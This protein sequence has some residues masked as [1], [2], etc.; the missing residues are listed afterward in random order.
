MSFRG[1]FRTATNDKY[2]DSARMFG[3]VSKNAGRMPAVLCW[4]KAEV[5]CFFVGF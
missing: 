5:V 4:L 2:K 3:S 1:S